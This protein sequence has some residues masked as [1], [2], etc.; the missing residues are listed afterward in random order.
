[1]AT[2]GQ[3]TPDVAIAGV[4]LEG[5]AKYLLHKFY[6]PD[7]PPWGTPLTQIEDLILALQ[8]ALSQ[9]CFTL[10]LTQQAQRLPD[11]G[12]LCPT[13]G[14]PLSFSDPRTRSAN[15][16]A[17]LACWQEPTAHCLDC[18]RD[19]FPQSRSL[20]IDLSEFSPGLLRKVI[21]VGTRCRSFVEADDL[22]KELLGLSLGPKQIERL[23][24]R[25]G[26]E[27]VDE[28]DALTQR[29]EELPLAEKFAVPP[30]VIP[31]DLGV[32]MTDGGRFQ[33]RSRPQGG[34]DAVADD[35]PDTPTHASAD[36]N[37]NADAGPDVQDRAATGWQDG[38]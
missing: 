38:L 10:A 32:I 11:A 13:C 31:P 8:R 5:V 6:G 12:R 1:M 28:R 7:G 35:P 23:I 3:S 34:A 15:T 21:S 4:Y 33:V 18:R 24:H 26:Q 17:G 9:H 16:R 2:T 22:L 30:G 14:Q 20:G 25:I 29:F 36:T 19:C 37:T 27:R